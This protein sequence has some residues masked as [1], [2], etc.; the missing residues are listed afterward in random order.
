MNQNFYNSNSFGFDQSQPSQFPVNHQP[1]Q[2]TSIETLHD[3]ENEIDSVQTFLRKFN[4]ISF[5]ETPEVLLLAW[6]KIFKIKDAFGNKQYKPEDTLELFRDLFNDVQ[7]IREELAVY[8]NTPGWNRPAFYNSDDDDDEDCVTE[9]YI[10]IGDCEWVC[11]YGGAK[12]RLFRTA[13]DKIEDNDVLDF[14]IRLFSVVGA[15]EYDLPTSRTLGAIV[16]ETVPDTKTDYDV[17]IEYKDGIPHRRGLPRCHTLVWVDPKDKIQQAVEIDRYILAEFP[18]LKNNPHAYKGLSEMMVYGLCGLADSEAV[19]T[20]K[21]AAQIVRPV[22]EPP[23]V[24]NNVSIKRGVIQNFIDGRYIC[25]HEA[26]W[27]II[28]YEIHSRQPA[29]Q[30]LVVQLENMQSITFIDRQPLKLLVNDEDPLRLWKAYWR[31]MSE[32]IPKTTSRTLHIK[33]LYMNDPE[34]EGVEE[35]SYNRIKLA[36]EVAILVPMLNLDQKNIYD[37]ILDATVANRHEFIFVYGHGG[38]RKTFLWKVLI[39][40]L[41]SQGKIVLA[42][43][44]SGIASLLLSERHHIIWDESPLNDMQCFETLD[45]TPKDILDVPHKLFGGKTIVLGGDFRQTLPVKKGASKSEIIDVENNSNDNSSW[46]TIPKEYCIPDDDNGLASLIGFIYDE[47]TLQKQTTH[48]L[49]QKAIVRLRNDIVDSINR[50]ILEMLHGEST[51]YT[52]SDEAIPT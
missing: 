42:V 3:Q 13:R 35:K 43:A 9:L 19:C 46:I 5:F 25:P 36:K 18:D 7:N 34:L 2:K 30:I 1:P 47:Q 48:D 26:C 51:I 40:A 49:Q 38:T 31:E 17:I 44:S 23:A 37:T 29:V 22:G 52:S 21:I 6:D 15:R 32:D 27:R 16:F 10:D 20:Y 24:T 11:E 39:S 14:Q 8:I 28:K 4:R 33:G 12:F 41:R 50:T 45:R